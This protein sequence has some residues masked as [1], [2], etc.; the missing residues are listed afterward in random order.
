MLTIVSAMVFV[1]FLSVS[2]K[3]FLTFISDPNSIKNH[4]NHDDDGGFG[5]I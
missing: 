4:D 2:Q 5:D 3:R 1:V